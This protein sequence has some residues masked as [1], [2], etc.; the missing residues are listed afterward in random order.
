MK[1]F[2]IAICLLPLCLTAQ[3][4][5]QKGVVFDD[6]N[7]NG[8]CD[9][10]EKGL[11]KVSVSNGKEVVQTNE[12]GEYALPYTDD[13]IFFVIKP[14]G[15]S[16]PADAHHLPQ[17]FRIHK[18]KG[19]P[20][21]QYAGVAPTPPLPKSLDFPLKK[22][23]ENLNFKALVLGDPQTLNSQ[24]VIS[25]DKGV[26]DELVKVKGMSFG[27]SLGDMSSDSLQ[28]HLP[29]IKSISRVGLPWYH[30]I[31]NHDLNFDVQSDSLS[32]ET[33]E[34][35][36]G[37]ANYAFNY[38]NT[39]F[40]VLDDIIYPD[41]RGKTQYFGGF[42]DDQLAFLKNNLELV[43]KD[44]L[45][46]VA[47]HIPL[48][49]NDSWGDTFNPQ[50][51]QTFFDLLKDFPNVLVLSAH[52][53][54]QHQFFWKAEDGWKG[55][56]PLHEYNV[57]T[58]SGSWYSGEL[59]ER[60]IP[61]STMR[62]GTPKGFAIL[63]VENNQY[64]LDYKVI[65]QPEDY[66][67][68]IYAPKAL[69]AENK[70]SSYGIYVNYFMGH[71]ESDVKY[72]LD[73]EDWKPMRFVQEPDPSYLLLLTPWDKS[74]TLLPGKRPPVPVN[75]THLWKGIFPEKLEVGKHTFEIKVTDMFGRVSVEKREFIVEKNR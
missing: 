23:N 51:R 5:I 70:Y 39:H 24:D 61:A 30:V 54:V 68:Q 26:V 73:N 48:F 47:I 42:R 33:F 3:T 14:S 41:P 67:M 6:E 1:H 20:T 49:L 2:F 57:G 71:A 62:D 18:P 63:S 31:G 35:N 16:V 69:P 21:K 9:K 4:G 50:N 52:T 34:A 46:V 8:I 29:Y 66:I 12:K 22:N 13:T 27:I 11:A 44:K 15:Y 36:F 25:F 74:D 28:L 53:H 19:S 65:D 60:G 43:S 75:P 59:N 72:R 7:G 38:A 64:K 17:F 10:K 56:S 40:V 58:T 45:L 37:P 55:G 32:D